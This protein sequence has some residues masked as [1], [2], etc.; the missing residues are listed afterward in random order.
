[1]RVSVAGHPTVGLTKSYLKSP[2]LIRTLRGVGG[3][4]VRGLYFLK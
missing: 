3:R 1:M 4:G 2:K